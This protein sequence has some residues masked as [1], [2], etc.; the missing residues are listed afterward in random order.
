MLA[1]VFRDGLGREGG[2][3]DFGA[4]LSLDAMVR[5]LSAA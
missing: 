5:A 1:S 2:G 3:G 4:G